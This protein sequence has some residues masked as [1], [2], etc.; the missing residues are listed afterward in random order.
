MF[1]GV[2]LRIHSRRFLPW[3]Y[4]L[5]YPPRS[6]LS[7]YQTTRCHV[8]EHSRHRED[9][10]SYFLY[11]SPFSASIL[12]LSSSCVFFSFFQVFAV[13]IPPPSST[14]LYHFKLPSFF[15]F[16]ISLTV[17][18]RAT[19]LTSLKLEAVGSSETSLNI[20][21]VYDVASSFHTRI[22]KEVSW[23]WLYLHCGRKGD[24]L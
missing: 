16:L 15:P 12:I 13:Y 19:Y 7:T 8:R 9:F 24:A 22:Y 23:R 3:K 5:I 20:F 4:I 11:T 21:C 17:V 6:W 14:P 18:P 2:C 1:F 10:K